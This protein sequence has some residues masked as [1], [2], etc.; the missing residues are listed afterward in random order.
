MTAIKYEKMLAEIQEL[1]PHQTIATFIFA[2]DKPN[3]NN[4]GLPFSEFESIAKSAIGMPIKMRFTGYGTGNHEGSIPIGVIQEMEIKT[5]SDDFHQLIAKAALWVGEYPE[6]IAWL[7]KAFAEGRAPGISYEINYKDFTN[8]DNVQWIKDTFAGA[9]TF[10]K[11]PAYGTRT[12]LIALAST[13]D[14]K[15]LEEGLIALAEQL[16]EE[17]NPEPKGGKTMDEKEVEA[18]KTER[19]TFKSEAATK[20]SEI[21][22]LSTTLGTKDAEIA[23]LQ[24]ENE[25]LKSAALVDS[26]LREYATAGFTLEA[27][28]E[29]ADKRKS[30]FASLTD[31]QWTD[32]IADLISVKA[33]QLPAPSNTALASLR[34]QDVPKPE[35]ATSTDIQSLRQ[36]LR[37]LARPNE[38]Q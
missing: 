31:E 20:Q 38:T 14:I 24:T 28:A 17:L 26:R 7:K 36:G 21:E 10:V 22:N 2:D 23:A 9:A 6:E 12:A 4:Q 27:E 18:L 16:T 3:N 33:T 35:L 34:R 29:K 5:I 15:K 37:S 25:N 30:L 19:D 32:Y 11:T 8:V 1:N 13:T